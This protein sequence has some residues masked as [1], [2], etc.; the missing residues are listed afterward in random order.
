[1]WPAMLVPG[2]FWPV[3]PLDCDPTLCDSWVS[4]SVFFSFSAAQ[5]IQTRDE[6]AC[7]RPK[8]G[9]SSQEYTPCAREAA[10]QEAL[11]AAILGLSNSSSLTAAPSTSS[12]PSS[13]SGD[14]S[15]PPPPSQDVQ[16]IQEILDVL[17]GK[18]SSVSSTSKL[19]KRLEDSTAAEKPEKQVLHKGKGKEG[20][21]AETTA[22]AAGVTK[23]RGASSIRGRGKNAATKHISHASAAVGTTAAAKASRGGPSKLTSAATAKPEPVFAAGKLQAPR[24]EEPAYGPWDM[25]E[26]AFQRYAVVLDV[27]GNSWSSR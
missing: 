26:E 14:P 7:P 20:T 2:R 15:T 5:V 1:M 11:I 9:D 23:L 16:D 17:L 3:L 13:S 25:P 21:D 8:W 27:D 6:H 12:V 19:G 10:N 4:C 18:K 24:H 22:A